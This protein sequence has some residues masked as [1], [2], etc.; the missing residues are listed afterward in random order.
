MISWR[1]AVGSLVKMC[2]RTQTCHGPQLTGACLKHGGTR[3]HRVRDFKS[4]VL[5]QQYSASLSCKGNA[6]L[7]KVHKTNQHYVYICI[8]IYIYIYIY[9]SRQS[10][11]MPITSP[12]YRAS[13]RVDPVAITTTITTTTNNT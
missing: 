10:R 12:A 6:F 5:A 9:I 8:Y 1:N 7:N 3:I 11:D 4:L 13:S 2:C